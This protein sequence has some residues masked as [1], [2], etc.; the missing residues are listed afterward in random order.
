MKKK[1]ELFTADRLIEI[2]ENMGNEFGYKVDSDVDYDIENTATINYF[3]LR[4]KLFLSAVVLYGGIYTKINIFDKNGQNIFSKSVRAANF[5]IQE[6]RDVIDK[7]FQELGRNV[8]FLLD[9]PEKV[10]DYGKKYGWLGLEQEQYEILSKDISLSQK[11]VADMK[12]KGLEIPETLKKARRYSMGLKDIISSKIA[13]E[14][15]ATKKVASAMK[16]I[17]KKAAWSEKEKEQVG[18]LDDNAVGKFNIYQDKAGEIFVTKHKLNDNFVLMDT[19]ETFDDVQEKIEK[20]WQDTASYVGYDKELLNDKSIWQFADA[21]ED[22]NG[23]VDLSKDYATEKKA[24]EEDLDVKLKVQKNKPAGLD[25]S[26]P[27]SLPE[28]I[29][30]LMQ[31]LKGKISDV[32]EIETQLAARKAELDAKYQEAKNES[33]IVEKQAEIENLTNNIG[34][35]LFAAKNETFQFQDNLVALTHQT[36]TVPA[37]ATD[38]WKFEKVFAKLQELM[39]NDNAQKFLDATL[40]GLQSQATEKTITE[41]NIFSPTQKQMKK[42]DTSDTNSFIDALKEIYTNLRS[43]F[44]DVKKANNILEEQLATGTTASKKQVVSKKAETNLVEG[45]WYRLKG[46]PYDIQF[47]GKITEKGEAV[48]HDRKYREISF[49]KNFEFIETNREPMDEEGFKTLWDWAFTNKAVLRYTLNNMFPEDLTAFSKWMNENKTEEEIK[50]F[51]EKMPLDYL[52]KGSSKK[53]KKVNKK[54]KMHK[55]A[56]DNKVRI[57]LTNLGK[58]NEGELVGEW[59]DLPVQ[60]FKPILDKI[61]IDGKNYE[62]VFI[63]DYE[64]PFEIGEYENIN[65]L[66]E[67]VK[68]IEALD[69]EQKDILYSLADEWDFDELYE[70]VA[71]GNYTYIPQGSIKNAIGE[72]EASNIDLAYGYIDM[73]GGIEGMSKETLE[74]YFDYDSFGETLSYDYTTTDKGY[75]LID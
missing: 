1:A 7:V 41:L 36:K 49:D 11:A 20:D 69:E 5:D 46:F 65:A 32:K 74:Q 66:N 68:K 39:G 51:N 43:Y 31:D 50:A 8:R 10:Y 19:A 6:Y 23:I 22:E 60:N 25:T 17:N 24:A 34:K 33:K 35:L 2:L 47:T 3:G 44:I 13:K 62:E 72:N 73:L 28:S 37:K 12:N 40:N 15:I 27:K 48:F 64:A 57:F 29:R 70:K 53:A 18:A 61:G 56:A 14:K 71:N 55:K 63:T 4:N 54:A 42:S 38:K 30:P 52:M 59:V 26:S 21:E 45:K 58:Y 67:K 16:E 75:V 9:T